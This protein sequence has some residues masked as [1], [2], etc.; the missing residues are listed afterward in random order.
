MLAAALAGLALI[1]CGKAEIPEGAVVLDGVYKAEELPMPQT[2]R[3]IG[4]PAIS[5]GD[6]Y[7]VEWT[8][9][10]G[11][12]L[13]TGSGRRY[14]LDGLGIN[15]LFPDGDEILFYGLDYNNN[16]SEIYGVMKDGALLWSVPVTDYM[17]S[18]LKSKMSGEI[19]TL[20]MLRAK[21]LWYI[22]GERDV[23]IFDKTG[24]VQKHIELDSA[25]KTAFSHGD[26]VSVVSQKEHIV[27]KGTERSD[28][29][30]WSDLLVKYD[31]YGG[32]DQDT[33]LVKIGDAMFK[34]S[35]SDL[36]EELLINFGNSG[37]M[38]ARLKRFIYESDEILWCLIDNPAGPAEAYRLTRVGQKI[39]DRGHVVNLIYYESGGVYDVAAYLFNKKQDEY[40]VQLKPYKCDSFDEYSQYVDL[41]VI[42]GGDCDLL[43]LKRDPDKYISKGLFA[44]LYDGVITPGELFTPVRK[45]FER[46]G[47]LPVVP[48]SFSAY[49]MLSDGSLTDGGESWTPR[50]FM[51]IC[52]SGSPIKGMTSGA[53]VIRRS[54]FDEGMYTSFIGDSFDKDAFLD[55]AAFYQSDIGGGNEDRG[56]PLDYFT[57]YGRYGWIQVKL[58]DG[59]NGYSVIGSPTSNGGR[60]R[61]YGYEQ[62]AV[63]KDSPST[64][65]AKEFLKYLLT[66]EFLTEG[67]RVTCVPSTKEGANNARRWDQKYHAGYAIH[68][69]SGRLIEVFGDMLD[70]NGE[71][72]YTDLEGFVP[73]DDKLFGEYIAFIESIEPM[74]PIPDAVMDM[75]YEELSAVEGGRSAEEIAG[76]LESRINIYLQENG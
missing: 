64:D 30:S 65:G 57:L 73:D 1:S 17:R 66:C 69:E 60:F 41:T 22:I 13:N 50:R 72:S 35:A 76:I 16:N 70:E 31:I 29:P 33:A 34:V 48:L 59:R 44:D 27:L 53:E 74:E 46:D 6:T 67:G 58:A 36:S 19:G 56:Y 26:R 75:I 11:N 55:F 54:G 23:V 12:Y 63:P 25:V 52:R 71:L 68:K 7:V 42:S 45:V 15:V 51:E 21:D 4:S 40:F 38:G 14:P 9:D 32:V 62:L 49:G 10:D 5:A 47:T 20:F 37:L 43:E 18:P 24:A 28:G 8:L 61:L 2:T 3:V 39:Y